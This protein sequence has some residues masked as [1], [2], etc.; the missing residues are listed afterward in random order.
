MEG[1]VVSSLPRHGFLRLDLRQNNK[2][3]LLLEWGECS[4]ISN[5]EAAMITISETAVTVTIWVLT[6]AGTFFGGRAAWR[7][8]K[9]KRA[10]ERKAVPP[11]TT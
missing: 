7:R 8:R 3:F 6:A 10:E 1:D 2:G 4:S 9:H 5:R 11:M